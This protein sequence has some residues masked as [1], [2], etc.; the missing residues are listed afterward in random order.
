MLDFSAFL[1]D[2]IKRSL[3]VVNQ[4]LWCCCLDVLAFWQDSP[5]TLSAVLAV[6]HIL[7]PPSLVAEWDSYSGVQDRRN[8]PTVPLMQSCSLGS[9]RDPRWR[10]WSMGNLTLAA[11]VSCWRSKWQCVQAGQCGLKAGSDGCLLQTLQ[12]QGQWR[13]GAKPRLQQMVGW[14]SGS[15]HRHSDKDAPISAGWKVPLYSSLV[16]LFQF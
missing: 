5:A 15:S 12:G 6:H 13:E 16:R 11:P 1:R 4:L 2:Y 8:E 3:P 10:F 14:R 9:L 7:L